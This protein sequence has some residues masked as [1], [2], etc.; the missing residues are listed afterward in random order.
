MNDENKNLENEL[1]EDDELIVVEEI[2]VS[3]KNLPDLQKKVN[4]KI[5]EGYTPLPCNPFY[6]ESEQLWYKT[7]QYEEYESELE[8]EEKG[9]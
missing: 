1:L 7:L 8:E 9:K 5:E 3:A 6:V 4:K 2:Y